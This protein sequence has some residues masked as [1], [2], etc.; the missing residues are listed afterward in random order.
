MTLKKMIVISSALLVVVV[1]FGSAARLYDIHLRTRCVRNLVAIRGAVKA[2]HGQLTDGVDVLDELVRLG[3]L[4]PAERFDPRSQRRFRLLNK[5]M[6]SD[7]DASAY[8][9]VYSE[10]SCSLLDRW[11][12]C[13]VNGGDWGGGILY[14]GGH[15]AFHR[16]AEYCGVLSEIGVSC[17]D[18]RGVDEADAHGH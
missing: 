3:A 1:L 17:D 13:F 9:L 7:L 6:R 16:R 11:F 4:Q 8:P 5:P 10:L 15:V 12:G 14:S 2:Y 18:P